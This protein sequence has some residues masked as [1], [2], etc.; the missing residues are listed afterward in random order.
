MRH[1][2]RHLLLPPGL[3]AE[4]ADVSVDKDNKVKVNHVCR[5]DAGQTQG[6]L[7]AMP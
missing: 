4:V 1:G 7:D 2:D 6:K 3:F 5:L